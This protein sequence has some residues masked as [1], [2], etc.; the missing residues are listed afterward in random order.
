M[1]FFCL[2]I[3]CVCCKIEQ[4]LRT[5]SDDEQSQTGKEWLVREYEKV[6]A[7]CLAEEKNGEEA[8]RRLCALIG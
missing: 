3:K 6:S 1:T 8:K 4:I 2:K 5:Q 7:I